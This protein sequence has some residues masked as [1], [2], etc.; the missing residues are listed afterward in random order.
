MNLQMGYISDKYNIYTNYQINNWNLL[1]YF[2][3]TKVLLKNGEKLKFWKM[4]V[5]GLAHVT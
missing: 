3:G 1:S 2:E 5:K 4:N